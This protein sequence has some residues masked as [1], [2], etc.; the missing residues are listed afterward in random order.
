M[1]LSRHRHTVARCVL[2]LAALCAF[3]ARVEAG[4]AEDVQQAEA[5]IRG[6]DVFT[7]MGLLR[8]AADQNNGAAQARLADLLHA[9]EFDTEAV[10][11]Y[12]KAAEQGEAA[13]EYGLGK[14]YADGTG[15]KADPALALEWF[16]KAEK[17]DYQPAVDALAR[18][19]RMGALGL[20]KDLEQAGALDARSRGLLQAAKGG[21]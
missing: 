17:K 2:S 1:K 10:A 8:R 18:A 15:L 9:A 5:S 14:M 20:P 13:G 7:A 11:L 16:R 3:G 12:R 21:K 4:P 19:Y 6:G